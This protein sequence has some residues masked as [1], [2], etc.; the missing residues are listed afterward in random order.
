[1]P[2]W[3][4]PACARSAIQA[5]ALAVAPLTEVIGI[6]VEAGRVRGVRTD[7]GTIRTESVVVCC[8][9]WSPR[10]AGMAG[11]SI[12]L[13]PGV[14]QM[15]TV[16]PVP[17]FTKMSGE[18]NFPV[19]RDMDVMMYE[20]QRHDD[21]EI[22]SY[23]HRPILWEPA[24]IPSIET[25]VLSPTEMPFTSEDFDPQF[26]NARELMPEVLDDAGVG[27]RRAIN[28]LISLTPDGH[29]VVGESPE[30]RGLWSAAAI[31]IKE[32]AGLARTLAEWM[33][34]GSPAIDPAS[35]DIAR[36][37]DFQQVAVIRPQSCERMVPEV[38][39]DRPS[40]RAMGV[41]TWCSAESDAR[42]SGGLGAVF[43][44]SA[45]WERPH[46]YAANERLLAKYGARVM[47]S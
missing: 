24:D 37:Y 44:E 46:W 18:I 10:L 17:Q 14:H 30:V 42:S 4:G 16:G 2:S 47:P 19:V 45:G 38:L 29:P 35:V 36:F 20:R 41:R 27:I 25:A 15:I 3:L 43:H 28:G 6:D 12:P 5:G 26:A 23:A 7:Q 31:W 13:M 8:G 21:M 33:T 11:A 39:C 9:V 40:C 1:M 34:H 22:G 32:A